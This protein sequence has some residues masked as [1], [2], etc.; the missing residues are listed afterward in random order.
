M[1]SCGLRNTPTFVSCRSPQN[2]VKANYDT[3]EYFP[4]TMATDGSGYSACDE[5]V[6]TDAGS[7]KSIGEEHRLAGV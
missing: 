2:P 7:E 5:L 1:A 3:F 4:V 6:S